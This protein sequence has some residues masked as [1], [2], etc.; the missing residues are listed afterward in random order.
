MAEEPIT[1]PSTPPFVPGITD[2]KFAP[3]VVDELSSAEDLRVKI[4]EELGVAALESNTA[5]I[6]PTINF[7]NEEETTK[8]RLPFFSEFKKKIESPTEY[9]T[10]RSQ[11]VWNTGAGAMVWDENTGQERW[12]L[13]HQSGDNL[14]F[15]NK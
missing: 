2:P 5:D 15:T 3:D 9:V 6:P 11:S 14:N 8:E 10:K 1:P 12:M 7:E 4:D 13:T